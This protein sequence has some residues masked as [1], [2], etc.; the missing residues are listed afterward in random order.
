M[1]LRGLASSFENVDASRIRAE[2]LNEITKISSKIRKKTHQNTV[3]K[4]VKIPIIKTDPAT[5]AGEHRKEEGSITKTCPCV[6]G[7]LLTKLI[8]TIMPTSATKTMDI[9]SRKG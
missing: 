1:L 4:A 9:R 7:S 2:I 5:N 3:Y 6:F 8:M